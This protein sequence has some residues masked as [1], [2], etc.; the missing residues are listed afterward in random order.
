MIKG[1]KNKAWNLVFR[2]LEIASIRA[3]GKYNKKPEKSRMPLT[4]KFYLYYLETQCS[5]LG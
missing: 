5:I 4:C 1:N 2:E 3:F